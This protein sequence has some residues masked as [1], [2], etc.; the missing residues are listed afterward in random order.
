MT[1]SSSDEQ[2]V[3]DVK[4][5][6]NRPERKLKPKIKKFYGDHIVNFN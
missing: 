6:I 4:A 5:K 3:G 1:D 2:M